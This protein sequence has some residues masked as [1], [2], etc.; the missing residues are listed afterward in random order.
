MHGIAGGSDN[1]NSNSDAGFASYE[2]SGTSNS[3][4]D[5][6]VDMVVVF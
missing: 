6:E 3:N 1:G 2:I 5:T 4:A